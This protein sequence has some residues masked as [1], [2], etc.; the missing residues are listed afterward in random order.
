MRIN[1][2]FHLLGFGHGLLCDLDQLA[3]SVNQS[4]KIKRPVNQIP[5]LAG[6]VD[7]YAPILGG[8]LRVVAAFARQP[9]SGIV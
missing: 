9:G 1:R 8:L 3:Q 7:L 2:V 6:P 5:D 4:R